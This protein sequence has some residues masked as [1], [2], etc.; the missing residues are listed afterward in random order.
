[1]S[2]FHEVAEKLSEVYRDLTTMSDHLVKKRESALK[3]A[4]ALTW[5]SVG[6]KW[7]ELFKQVY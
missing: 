4:Q 3:W 1:M 7:V 2:D 6:E 5:E